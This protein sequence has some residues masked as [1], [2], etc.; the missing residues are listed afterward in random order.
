MLNNRF[1]LRLIAFAPFCLA[2][3]D[4]TVFSDQFS[5]W[6]VFLLL[7]L[8]LFG[9]YLFT[10][11]RH[12]D[13][14][15]TTRK[16][17]ST[18]PHNQSKVESGN[19]VIAPNA[20]FCHN[21]SRIHELYNTTAITPVNS[22]LIMDILPD[23][24]WIKDCN[25]KYLVANQEYAKRLGF[26]NPEHMIGKTDFDICSVEDADRYT[27]GD[28][29]VFST[30]TQLIEESFFVHLDG[31]SGWFSVSKTPMIDANGNCIGL[32][33]TAHNIS[34]RKRTE[35]LLQQSKAELEEMVRDRT[36]KLRHAFDD[37]KLSEERFR[38]IIQ[39]QTEM[40]CRFNVDGTYSFVNETFAR[41]FGSR[42]EL[43]IGKNFYTQIESEASD[44]IKSLLCSI[45]STNPTFSTELPLIDKDGIKRWTHWTARGL[46]D[47][48]GNLREVQAVGRDISERVHA[49]L[50]LREKQ[51]QIDQLIEHVDA[52]LW[53]FDL[54]T[55]QYLFISRQVEH[56]LGYPHQD[57]TTNSTFWIDHVHPEDQL[58]AIGK[59]SISDSTE[60]E[61]YLE[62]RMI[63][64]DGRVIWVLDRARIYKSPTGNR[65]RGVFVD[66]T[67][68]KR[69]ELVR[70]SLLEI[71]RSTS[72]LQSLEEML[73]AVHQ[74]VNTLMDASN[75]FVALYDPDEDAYSFPYSF[76]PFD[77]PVP[78]RTLIPLKKSLTDYVRRTGHALFCDEAKFQELTNEGEVELVGVQSVCWLGVPLITQRGVIGVTV[79]Q[80]YATDQIYTKSDFE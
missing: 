28:N 10:I 56:L 64:S 21:C 75:F 48:S 4:V 34:D 42:S 24:V 50:S 1:P 22:K 58:L 33:G 46:F 14:E 12:I 31:T 41:F 78:T 72:A 52:V 27:A 35:Q 15:L 79:A 51:L 76:D 61:K 6:Q 30:K 19:D 39:D 32:L 26:T 45:S 44:Y 7:G 66:I 43:V 74:S 47:E 38:T 65:L 49:E 13:N 54:E 3:L 20:E 71:M 2:L 59:L 37:L 77:E 67:Q 55:Y 18:L 5:S 68:K 63:T 57:W 69:D 16:T 9:I 70:N 25:G 36:M 8:L 29:Q 40:I 60:L 11:A 53:E 23:P 73:A 80:T 17:A 62:Y